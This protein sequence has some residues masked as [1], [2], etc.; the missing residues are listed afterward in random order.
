VGRQAGIIIDVG[1]FGRLGLRPNAVAFQAERSQPVLRSVSVVEPEAGGAIIPRSH[2]SSAAGQKEQIKMV[3][4]PRFE[5][6]GVGGGEGPW[7][8]ATAAMLYRFHPLRPLAV[9]AFVTVHS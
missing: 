5:P 1:G 6:T 9:P 2:A 7:R 3:A 8:R 4:G